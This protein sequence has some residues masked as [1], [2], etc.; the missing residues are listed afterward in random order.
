MIVQVDLP[1]WIKADAITVWPW[2]FVRP[3]SAGDKALIE[4]ELVHYR[5]Q[6]WL[7][8]F[9]WL[10]Y[11]LAAKFRLSAELRGYGKQIEL[12]GISVPLAA[13]YLSTRYRLDL[14]LAEAMDLLTPT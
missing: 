1:D 7:T 13:H 14:S 10:A 8:P 12:K 3:A 6:A 2:V 9:W 4:H 11:L 5:E